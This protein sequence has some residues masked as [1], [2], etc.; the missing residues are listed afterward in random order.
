MYRR[1]ISKLTVKLHSQPTLILNRPGQVVESDVSTVIG[2]KNISV[3]DIIIQLDNGHALVHLKKTRTIGYCVGC[4][5]QLETEGVINYKDKLE[6]IF[7]YCPGCKGGNWT[8]VMCFASK[9]HLDESVVFEI[10]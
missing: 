10:K 5:K 3:D 8:C 6:K 9:H 2:A 1:P 4:I 7:T